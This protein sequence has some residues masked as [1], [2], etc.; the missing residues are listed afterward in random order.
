MQLPHYVEG[1]E[2]RDD[3][4]LRVRK[5]LMEEWDPIGVCGEP[6][7]TNEY[8]N[9]IPAI[10]HLLLSNAS[11]DQLRDYLF[12]IVDERMGMSPPATR[13]HMKPAAEALKKL[14][15]V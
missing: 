7:A 8:D 12:E 9:Y 4:W 6:N 14:R 1:D 13:E 10:L 15:F 3:R 5:V 11:V 2:L